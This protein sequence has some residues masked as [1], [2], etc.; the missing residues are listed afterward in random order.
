MNDRRQAFAKSIT[1]TAF[2]QTQTKKPKSKKPRTPKLR[3][4][5]TT[6]QAKQRKSKRVNASVVKLEG[7]YKSLCASAAFLRANNIALEKEITRLNKLLDACVTNE[8]QQS[9][10]NREEAEQRCLEVAKERVNKGA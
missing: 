3:H 9:K 10:V 2:A 1:A 4:P 5:S 7:D 8:T 6:A